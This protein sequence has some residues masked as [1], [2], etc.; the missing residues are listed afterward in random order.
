MDLQS[1]RERI[2]ATPL[3][4]S[5]PEEMR[6]RYVMMLLWISQTESVSRETILFKQGE[7]DAG[8]GCLILEGMVRIIADEREVKTIEAPDILGEVQLFTPQG[9]RTATVEV[10]VGGEVLKFE[11]DALGNIMRE[12]YTDEE[13]A[14]M[15]KMIA[16]SAWTRE[17]NLAEKLRTR[18]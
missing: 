6:Q 14:A 3:V 10:V 1:I 11:W 15:K 17:E 7:K 13:F 12:F 2:L 5:L 18:G 8:T 9:T 4:S 16:Q